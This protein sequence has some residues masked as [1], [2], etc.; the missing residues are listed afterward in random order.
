[1]FRKGIAFA[2][3][4]AAL[5]V[6]TEPPSSGDEIFLYRAVE[7]VSPGLF[8]LNQGN[9]GTCVSFGY[10]AAC[11]I[12][13]AMDKVAGKSSKFVPVAEESLYGGMRVEGAN[14]TFG[15]WSDGSS[16]YAAQRWLTKAGGAIYRQ[17]YTF[18]KYTVDLTKYDPQRARNW[19]AYGNGGQEDGPNNGPLDQEARKAP[20]KSAVLVKTLEE[21][22]V[23]L[24][25]GYPV[26]ICSGQGFSNVR[27]KDGFCRA[28]G[29]W[30]HC[31]VIVGKRNG[32]R[33]GYLILNSWGSSWVSGP[34]YRDQ[35]DG[36]FYA[37]P[38]V[39]LRILQANDSYALSGQS[40]FVR[41][42]LPF[43]MLSADAKIPADEQPAP[44]ADL[45][46]LVYMG[47]DGVWYFKDPDTN[48]VYRYA[49]GKWW[50]CS[51]GT[52]RSR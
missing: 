51:S 21:L 1:M 12:L 7:K 4:A 49:A 47:A 42:I 10:G 28:Q 44:K 48:V 24:K 16:G 3:V 19:G 17:V 2:I 14:R 25:N 26:P 40:G 46:S 22:D 41:N 45:D 6:R 30:A 23:A 43:W 29:R 13:L 9:V 31:M 34:K 8:P 38:S 35:P 27:D 20:V 52:C 36:S 39:V 11:D 50:D 5:L 37:E 33:K 32:G 15:G 18:P